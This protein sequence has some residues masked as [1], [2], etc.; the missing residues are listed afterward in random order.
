MEPYCV[1]VL[2]YYFFSTAYLQ[3]Q[4]M[5]IPI[6]IIFK[7]PPVYMILLCECATIYHF[8]V[9]GNLDC[10]YS[11][12]VPLQIFLYHCIWVYMSKSLYTYMYICIYIY[13]FMYL[14]NIFIYYPGY[15]WICRVTEYFYL[16]LYW[17]LPNFSL[18]YLYTISGLLHFH[19]CLISS[20]MD[21][22]VCLK[23]AKWNNTVV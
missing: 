10:F 19:Q 16:L 13:T 4:S 22:S 7:F 23:D 11:F 17:I 6:A 5:L 12:A 18:K 2:W 9:N 3:C 21:I 14:C 8:P 1:D 15:I 20:D